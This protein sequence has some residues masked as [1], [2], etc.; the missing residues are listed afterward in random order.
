MEFP[1]RLMMMMMNS[2]FCCSAV[3]SAT[4]RPHDKVGNGGRPSNPLV[5]TVGVVLSANEI[6]MLDSIPSS[7]LAA[8]LFP[9][10]LC[11][12]LPCR[13]GSTA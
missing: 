5:C 12:E 2:L 4:V 7:I 3:E 6:E 1:F 11:V 8:F 9:R 13:K 10:L